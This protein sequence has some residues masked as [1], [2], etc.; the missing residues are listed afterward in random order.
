MPRNYSLTKDTQQWKH[1]Q[2]MNYVSPFVKDGILARVEVNRIA[3]KG[4]VGTF[5][6][7]DQALL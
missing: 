5:G 2:H 7:W 4:F 1:E 3:S 6:T